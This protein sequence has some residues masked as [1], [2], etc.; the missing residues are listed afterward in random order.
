VHEH[1]K[2]MSYIEYVDS[3]KLWVYNLLHR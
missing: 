1:E 2:L 3:N